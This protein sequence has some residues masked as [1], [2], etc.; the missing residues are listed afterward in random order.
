MKQIRTRCGSQNDQFGIG[1]NEFENW[2]WIE[3]KP[4]WSKRKMN[5]ARMVVKTKKTNRVW[6]AVDLRTKGIKVRWRWLICKSKGRRLM[7]DESASIDE[8]STEVDIERGCGGQIQWNKINLELWYYVVFMEWISNL[9]IIWQRY[10]L[11][12]IK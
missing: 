6:M 5:Q 9:L 2:R 12:Y 4:N 1:V 8:W 3:K 10:K 11:K 7:R